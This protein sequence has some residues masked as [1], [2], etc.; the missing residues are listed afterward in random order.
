MSVLVQPT[1]T[2]PVQSLTLRAGTAP[3]QTPFH[4]VHLRM[5]PL[6]D[7]APRPP[8]HVLCTVDVSGSMYDLCSDGRSKLECVQHTIEQML[9]LLRDRSAT[10]GR[11]IT[12]H[13]Q[14]FDGETRTVVP[15]TE[16]LDAVDIERLVAQVRAIEPAGIT[17]IERA[18]DAA[19]AHLAAHLAAHPQSEA[20]HLFLTDGEITEGE[21]RAD[22]L[23]PRLLR[24][25]SVTHLFLGF[26]DEHDAVLL[27][28]LG[29]TDARCAYRF[30][31]VMEHAGLVYGEL[32]HNAVYQ[33][34]ADACLVVQGGEVYDFDTD[35]WTTDVYT[36]PLAA[37][38]SRTFLV[39]AQ[40]QAQSAVQVRLLLERTTD[41]EVVSTVAGQPDLETEADV[42]YWFKQR[43]QSLL[44]AARHRDLCPQPWSEPQRPDA[45]DE[46]S[47]DLRLGRDMETDLGAD[48]VL[49]MDAGLGLG[50][51]ADLEGLLTP[52]PRLSGRAARAGH[53][54]G[55]ALAAQLAACEREMAAYLEAH[56]AARHEGN[57]AVWQMLADDLRI[58]RQTLG[59]RSGY[60][61]AHAR[62]QSNGREHSY[63]CSRPLYPRAPRRAS[64]RAAIRPRVD[65]ESNAESDAESNAEGE[66]GS[67]EDSGDEDAQTV[68]EGFPGLPH[69]LSPNT[70]SSQRTF[71]MQMSSLSQT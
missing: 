57:A 65:S 24:H 42:V 61:Y 10:S 51:D 44:Y 46:D 33:L 60:M 17:N 29:A 13:L 55:H 64:R 4:V 52:L 62:Q 37:E 63:L 68:A 8:L 14:T 27:S 2:T 21:A 69:F 41:A 16:R 71:M 15:P 3:D 28:A 50:L 25:S 20:V 59:T 32:V 58:V 18:L 31:D 49:G 38:Q 66:W 26:G 23:Q 6:D 5:R 9:R 40:P 54:R 70:T 11:P 19:S 47:Q 12:F 45:R 22:W 34:A 48:L 39:R 30:I 7:A 43:V 35:R 67:G 36:G 53:G 56:P 1:N